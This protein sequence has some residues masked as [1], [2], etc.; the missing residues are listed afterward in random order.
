M[1]PPLEGVVLV[2]GASSGI[3]EALARE[4]APRC[5]VLVLVARRRRELEALAAALQ[6]QHPKLRVQVESCDLVE[7]AQVDAMLASVLKSC[8]QIDVLVNNA[9]FGDMTLFDRADWERTSRMIELNVRALTYLTHQVLGP[10]VERQSGG[11][12]NIS[13]SFGM[14]FTPGFAAYIATKHY[15]TGFT[16]ALRLDLEGT[17]V[18]VTQSCPGPVATE[19][20]ANTNN[21]TGL[22]VPSLIEISASQCARESLRAFELGRAMIIPGFVIWV[23]MMLNA[24]TP[25]PILR[26]LMGQAAPRLRQMQQQGQDSGS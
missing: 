6:A 26:M 22:S 2:T 1:R 24:L 15:V 10:M 17:G 18:V 23:A 25:R 3:G 21:F 14:A 16:E 5:R 19:F 13:S 20:A 7:Q 4:L 8:G 12:L 11:I 9:G